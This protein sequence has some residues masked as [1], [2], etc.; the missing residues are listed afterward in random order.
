MC[1]V[2]FVFANINEPGVYYYGFWTRKAEND[3]IWSKND[4]KLG[5]YG[6]K[7]GKINLYEIFLS[8][9]T[10]IH[11]GTLSSSFRAF[12]ASEKLLELKLPF[13]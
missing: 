4:V 1:V 9:L 7:V 12:V 10:K 8:F 6:S 11:L 2:L 13:T 5:E 3:N